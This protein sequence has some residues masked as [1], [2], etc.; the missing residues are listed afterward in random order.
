MS[1]IIG[2]L[3]PVT[4]ALL[5]A[6]TPTAA[7][8]TFF[9]DFTDP[10]A[11]IGGFALHED[12]LAYFQLEG[13]SWV[14]HSRELPDGKDTVLASVSPAERTHIGSLRF[15]GT[16]VAWSDDRT[17]DVEVYALEFATRQSFRITSTTGPDGDIA[18]H[19]GRLAWVHEPQLRSMTLPD[20]PVKVEDIDGLPREPVLM[21]DGYV[22][23]LVRNATRSMFHVDLQG[24]EQLLHAKHGS[25]PREAVS[26]GT[27]VAWLTPVLWDADQPGF[28]VK[29]IVVQGAAS[30]T[31]AVLNLTGAPIE[32][33]GI[34][35]GGGRVCWIEAARVRCHSWSGG[36]DVAIQDSGGKALAVSRT[37]VVLFRP[38]GTG[39]SAAMGTLSLVESSSGLSLVPD[40]PAPALLLGLA[41]LVA[42]RRR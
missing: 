23:A 30:V 35:A 5:L 33:N 7:A 10:V 34:A 3:A 1:R 19:D 16:W 21:D 25:M 41:L 22:L 18:L 28:G 31:D 27:A 32:V 20:G 26:D 15:D 39:A 9:R 13:D 8:K 40:W 38:A 29:G 42:W 37:H 2:W 17:G 24:Q 12:T 14:L 36:A 6:F 4:L 11:P